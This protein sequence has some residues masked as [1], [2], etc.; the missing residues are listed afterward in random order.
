MK[1]KFLFLLIFSFSFFTITDA[2][3]RSTSVKGY[4]R[5]DG[6]YVRPHTRSYNSGS[7]YSSYSSDS[8]L[9]GT[10]SSNESSYESKKEQ[11]GEYLKITS[12]YRGEKIEKS[13]LNT[14]Q[15]SDSETESGNIIYLSV[16]YYNNKII[17]VCPITRGYL[18]WEFDEVQHSFDKNKITPEDALDLVSNYGWSISNEKIRKNFKYV[19]YSDKKYPSYLLKTF[20]VVKLK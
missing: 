8:Y 3:K 5:K 19:S 9:T 12:N 20:E 4:T 2:Q 15:N 6:T 18:D 10:S 16:L 17:D 7:G 11:K 13:E 1:L 14:I